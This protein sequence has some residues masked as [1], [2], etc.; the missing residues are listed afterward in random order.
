MRYDKIEN[1]KIFALDDEKFLGNV[2]QALVI[3]DGRQQLIN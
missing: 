2:S 1:Q 3:V